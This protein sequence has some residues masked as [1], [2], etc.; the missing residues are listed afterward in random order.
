MK[1]ALARKKSAVP[2]FVLVDCSAWVTFRLDPERRRGETARI[3]SRAA[4]EKEASVVAEDAPGVTG[5]HAV[6]PDRNRDAMSVE[7]ARKNAPLVLI[8]S[9]PPPQCWAEERA[10]P[11]RKRA[12]KSAREVTETGRKEE[13]DAPTWEN[14]YCEEAQLGS[15]EPAVSLGNGT[16][17]GSR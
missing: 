8:F 7:D 13:V 10:S 4:H 15:W 6:A 16:F 9:L 17:G 5:C 2:A 1:A 12:A 3:G 14:E 11:K